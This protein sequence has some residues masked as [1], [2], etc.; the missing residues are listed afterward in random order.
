MASS[1]ASASLVRRRALCGA[2]ALLISALGATDAFAFVRF[3]DPVPIDGLPG[4]IVWVQRPGFGEFSEAA[5][6]WGARQGAAEVACVIAGSHRPAD[7]VMV[8]EAPPGRRVWRVAA[9]LAEI[10]VARSVDSLGQ[11]VVGRKVR[12]RVAIGSPREL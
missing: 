11:S 2:A 1:S 8:A 3:P 4:E 7:C 10:Y 12:F 9:R 6:A 5:N